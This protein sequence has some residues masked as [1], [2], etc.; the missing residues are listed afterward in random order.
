MPWTAG[1][2]PLGIFGAKIFWGSRQYIKK[3]PVGPSW[4]AEATPGGRASPT[5]W[6]AAARDGD[7]LDLMHP[8]GPVGGCSP[9]DGRQGSMNTG[10]RVRDNM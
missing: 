7:M 3:A 2:D 1:P 4:V 5:A 6:I 9:E 10:Q 8:S